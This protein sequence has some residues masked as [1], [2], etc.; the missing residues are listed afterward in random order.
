MKMCCWVLLVCGLCSTAFLGY[1]QQG[2]GM[3]SESFKNPSGLNKPLTWWHWINGNVTKAGIRKDLYD[4]KR[5]GIGGVQLFDTHMYL[6]KGPVRYG[7]DNWHEHVQYAIRVCDTLGLEFYM[8]NSPGWSGSGGPW[9]PVDRSM[10]MLVYSET[11]VKANTGTEVKLPQ[12]YR[13]HGFYED[14]AVLAIQEGSNHNQQYRPSTIK[15]VG[16]TE[17]LDVLSDHDLSTYWATS[18]PS[19]TLEAVFGEPVSINRVRVDLA[20]P[21]GESNFRGSIDLSEDGK[22]FTSVATFGFSNHRDT[23]GSF[24]IPFETVA[25]RVVRINLKGAKSSTGHVKEIEF[26]HLQSPEQWYQKTAA[27]KY[28]LNGEL[29][30][31]GKSERFSG[32]DHVL[33]VTRFFD[34][35]RGVLSW[36]PPEGRWTVLR[37]GYTTTGKK[38]H[39]AQD[40]GTG[41]EVDKLDPDAVRFQFEKSQGR[42]IREAGGLV[43]KT[44]KGIVFDSFEGGYQ[45]WTDKLPEMFEAKKGYSLIPY[46][47]LFAGRIIGSVDLSEAV[48][49]D[50]RQCITELIAE[51]FQGTMY[52][53]A[54][55]KGLSVYAE[56]QGGPISPAWGNRY[57]D[58][59]MNEFWTDGIERRIPLIRQAASVAHLLGKPIVGAEAF[60]SKPEFGKWQNVPSNLKR[61]GDVA[62]AAGINRFIFHTYTHQPYEVYPGFTMG[63]YGTHFGRT[64]T[65]WP[66]ARPWMDYI[67]RSQYL[68]QQG[69]RHADI[70][71][72]YPEDAI[73]E[74]PSGIPAIP[75]G[76]TF[77]ICYP[78]QL[79]DFRARNGEL[80]FPSGAN[81][82][83]LVLAPYPTMHVQTLQRLADLI[84]KGATIIGSPPLQPAGR[85]GVLSQHEQFT[86]LVSQL[87]G[88]LDGKVKRSK[89]VGQG[90]VYWDTAVSEILEIK[91]LSP[92]VQSGGIDSMMFAHRR[93]AADDIYFVVNRANQSVIEN[94]DFRVSGKRPEIWDPQTGTYH[95][96]PVFDT[97]GNRTS[98]PLRLAPGTSRFV[99]FRKPLP[100][101]WLQT[102]G[103][104]HTLPMTTVLKNDWKLS[105]VDEKQVIGLDSLR[106]WNTFNEEEIKYYSGAGIYSTTFSLRSS[107]RQDDRFLL[108]IGAYYDI[109][110]V[111]ING[112]TVGI[113]WDGSGQIELTNYVK[114]GLNDLQI[115]VI[116]RWVNRLIGDEQHPTSLRYDQSKNIFSTG[117]LLE[118]PDWLS[119]PAQRTKTKR[120][121]FTTWKH[122]QAD[123]PLVPSGLAGPVRLLRYK[124]AAND[125]Q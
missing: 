71:V 47:P 89:S 24:V 97:V 1:A 109:A 77:D 22:Q 59:P 125:T 26:R 111:D 50:F 36:A 95:D 93:S 99:V 82:Q 79:K 69:Q 90:T 43:G 62:F 110:K 41:Y 121:T 72:L 5:V 107:P 118:L 78:H 17:N 105:L 14:V 54:K 84:E 63:R 29:S 74:Q 37:F 83:V 57:T 28:P 122:Y 114:K 103:L 39:P 60:T 15:S 65:W 86:R 9:V 120:K 96:A 18:N 91:G 92:D 85:D 10:K 20:F 12:P 67:G 8:V 25:A 64:N 119:T 76:Y 16:S 34:R 38:I 61:I 11:A 51:N 73:Y 101:D 123:S 45:N 102:A 23:V 30:S 58:V 33:D 70:C 52:A 19:D 104:G 94:V 75:S 80:T 106:L 116:N 68:L 53:L 100:D 55:E 88:G 98:I 21:S 81:Y 44:F 46:L 49:W 124:T 48:L 3:D 108:D 27:T 112:I 7:S 4:M 6:P 87:W 13:Q 31:S 66:Y 115:T 117:R 56:S 32:V 2:K 40:E 113:V 35:K 42:I